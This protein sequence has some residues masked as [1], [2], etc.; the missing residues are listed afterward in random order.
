M[1]FLWPILAK[2]E[3]ICQQ[4]QVSG[5]NPSSGVPERMAGGWW[6]GLAMCYRYICPN[7]SLLIG[8]VQSVRHL[9]WDGLPINMTDLFAS[10]LSLFVI[11]TKALSH[12]GLLVFCKIVLQHLTQKNKSWYHLRT[13]YS[14]GVHILWKIITQSRNN[15]GPS[16][17]PS[18]VLFNIVM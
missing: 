9:S 3:L 10:M 18:L 16:M 11:Y 17:I 7:I 2:I 15:K 14:S 1:E 8:L 4:T 6:G 12:E 13:Y 5:A